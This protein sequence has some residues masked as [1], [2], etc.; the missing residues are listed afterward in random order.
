[1]P[2]IMS[3]AMWKV[4]AD[5]GGITPA[6]LVHYREAFDDLERLGLS[7]FADLLESELLAARAAVPAPQAIV[8][9]LTIRRIVFVEANDFAEHQALLDNQHFFQHWNDD[10]AILFAHLRGF[11]FHQRVDRQA[12]DNDF[13]RRGGNID[14]LLLRLDPCVN[15][16]NPARHLL[17]TDLDLFRDDGDD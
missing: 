12:F 8:Q 16:H 4:A 10:N 15:A 7:G 9:R 2:P 11:P 1:M 6:E 14:D 5:I 3:D 13:L 17:R